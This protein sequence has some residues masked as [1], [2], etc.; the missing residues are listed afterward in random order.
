M[1]YALTD[2]F[3][4]G[5][6][7]NDHPIDNP[8]VKPPANYHGGDWRGIEDKLEPGSELIIIPTPQIG[9]DR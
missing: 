2:R 8:N 3:N 7:T 5:D 4:D 1:Y 6:K 9:A